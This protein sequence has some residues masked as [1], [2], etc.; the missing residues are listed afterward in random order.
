MLNEKLAVLHEIQQ[1]NRYLLE[2]VAEQESTTNLLPLLLGAGGVAAGG[3]GINKVLKQRAA[4]KI[5]QG[6]PELAQ[7]A[8]RSLDIGKLLKGLGGAAAI[9]GLGIAGAQAASGLY[10]QYGPSLNIAQDDIYKAKFEPLLKELERNKSRPG[11]TRNQKAVRRMARKSVRSG[12]RDFAPEAAAELRASGYSTAQ[13]LR[14]KALR[15]P[16]LVGRKT[17]DSVEALKAL[18]GKIRG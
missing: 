12:I 6:A 13:K 14:D 15:N 1:E 4:E 16:S 11:H 3:Y 8:G 17:V 2:K 9:G 7:V 10:G 18:L 5:L